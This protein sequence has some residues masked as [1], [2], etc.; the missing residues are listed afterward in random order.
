MFLVHPTLTQAEID[1]T[2]KVIGKVL[3]EASAKSLV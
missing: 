1:L 2:C 3:S